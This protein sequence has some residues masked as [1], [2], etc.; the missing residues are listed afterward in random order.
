MRD[1]E[2]LVTLWPS[3]PHFPRFIKDH[4]LSGI[5]LNSA[6][7]SN[8][9]LEAELGLIKDLDP[10]LPLYFDV[11]GRQLRVEEVHLNPD[12]LDITLNHPISVELPALVIF[13]A[14]A[15]DAMLLRVEEDGKRL[16]FDGG[17]RF[18]VNPGESLHIKHPSLKVSGGLFSDLELAKIER[19]KKEGFTRFFLSYVES[20]RDVD[21]F[22]EI[23]G[24]DSEVWLKIENQKG[25][26]YV[27]N[28]F[29][30][31]PNLSLVAARGDLYIESVMP[32]DI[33]PAL[34][35]IIE[36]DPEACL[37]SR[38]LLSVVQPQLTEVK[39]ALYF[40]EA[41]EIDKTKVEGIIDQLTQPQ[42][43][44]CA[45]FCELAWLYDIGY[46]RMMLCDELCLKEDLLAEAINA[47]D[48]FRESYTKKPEV[49]EPQ[50]RSFLRRFRKH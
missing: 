37:G 39:R 38:I 48:A 20:Q 46:R 2:L 50:K 29:R 5:R 26:D 35:L 28:E 12:Y 25:L 8:P 10:K 11:K 7:I 49:V 40:M 14:G 27:A 18:M 42:E 4:R 17:P 44:S 19:V 13:K 3:F 33:L 41:N 34:K 15:D 36:K 21:E 32:H 23:V 16:I 1:L 22:L 30:K 24:S 9:E 31:K 45:D 43:P 6:M 47:F